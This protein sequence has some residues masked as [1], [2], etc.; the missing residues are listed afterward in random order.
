MTAG[1]QVKIVRDT[2]DANGNP[3]TY[4][5][6]KVRMD[7]KIMSPTGTKPPALPSPPSTAGGF[8]FVAT[9]KQVP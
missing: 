5:P 4:V 1:N 9:S 6:L 3:S 2:V 7:T 8:W